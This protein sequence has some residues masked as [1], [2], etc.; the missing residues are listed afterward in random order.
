[1]KDDD[2]LHPEETERAMIER[3]REVTRA[4]TAC[5]SEDVPLAAW[6]RLRVALDGLSPGDVGE[7]IRLVDRDHW[8]RS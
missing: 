1:M 5:Q 6:R 2:A 7:A 8:G 3:L 4:A